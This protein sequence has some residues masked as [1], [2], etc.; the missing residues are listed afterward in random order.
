MMSDSGDDELEVA[1]EML[2]GIDPN[3]IV[4]TDLDK[5]YRLR[6]EVNACKTGKELYI[7]VT[8]SF[9]SSG[10]RWGSSTS[11]NRALLVLRRLKVIGED[12]FT[13]GNAK[14][15]QKETIKKYFDEKLVSTSSIFADLKTSL[16]DGFA[17]RSARVA[18]LRMPAV[19]DEEETSPLNRIALLAVA[20]AHPGF[21][22]RFQVS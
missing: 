1:A 6:D 11:M 7:L 14:I 9:G 12:K 10:Y 5:Q 18:V 20:I 4:E 16:V 8:E 15:Q 2:E 21:N 3:E 17:K 19:D 22:N 13:W